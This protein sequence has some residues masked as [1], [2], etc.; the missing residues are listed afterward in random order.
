MW[1]YRKRIHDACEAL[2]VRLETITHSWD[3]HLGFTAHKLQDKHTLT[4]VLSVPQ[5]VCVC[6]CVYGNLPRRIACFTVY[7]SGTILRK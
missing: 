5:C 2:H 4:N 3:F 1:A 7:V 6:V